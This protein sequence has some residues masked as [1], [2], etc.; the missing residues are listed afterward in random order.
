V[1]ESLERARKA[2]MSDDATEVR[3]A[4]EELENAARMI[5]EAM[6]RPTGLSG[7]AST[8]EEEVS[9]FPEAS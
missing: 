6:F 4:L 1:R 8:N 7:S 5:T 2:A 3:S 9:T